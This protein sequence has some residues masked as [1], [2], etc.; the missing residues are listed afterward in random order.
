MIDV[1][2]ARPI[3]SSWFDQMAESVSIST[4]DSSSDSNFKDSTSHLEQW[5]EK[6]QRDINEEDEKETLV[7]AAGTVFL[8]I[9]VLQHGF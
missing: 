2:L 3:P 7:E 8:R 5:P 6:Q 4:W 1:P 9:A